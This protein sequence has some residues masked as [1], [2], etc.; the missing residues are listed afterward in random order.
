MSDKRLKTPFMLKCIKKG[1]PAGRQVNTNL[2]KLNPEIP[3]K[4]KY[5]LF[6]GQRRSVYGWNFLNCGRFH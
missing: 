4:K 3:V 5:G 6:S 1:N 2:E